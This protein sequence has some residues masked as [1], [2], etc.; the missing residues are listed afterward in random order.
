MHSVL[1]P[2]PVDG[3][4]VGDD[5]MPT[6]DEEAPDIHAEGQ[7]TTKVG[8]NVLNTIIGS[9]VLCLPYALHNAGFVFG[10]LMLGVIA[11]LSQFSLYALVLTGKRTG[12]SHFSSVTEAALGNFG[13]H[14]LNYSMIIDMVGT[15]ILYLMIVGDMVT[16]GYLSFGSS[17][18]ANILEN[19]PDSD[20]F[21]NCGRFLFAISLIFTTPLGFYPI[22]DT[23]TEM[24]KIDPERHQ[25]S[26]IWESLCTVLLFTICVVAAAVFTD[27]G[28][29]YELIGA[30]SSSV[31]NFLLPALVFLW[32]GTDVSLR[33]L[34]SQWRA[35]HSTEPYPE[36]AAFGMWVMVLGTYNISRDK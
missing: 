10:L 28:L 36:M 23:V 9:G 13:Y 16:A 27:L 1:E 26:R 7:S 22:R 14:L 19:F 17:A 6:S 18:Q 30:L 29:A 5:R 24:L 20:S 4:P 12:T 3:N 8:F 11:V 33:S 32:A 35:K 34:V 2:Q 21:I 31:V 25:V 15:V